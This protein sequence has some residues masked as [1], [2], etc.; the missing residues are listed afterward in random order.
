LGER[1]IGKAIQFAQTHPQS[2]D[3]KA[4]TEEIESLLVGSRADFNAWEYALKPLTGPSQE[5]SGWF[6]RGRFTIVAG[7]SGAM[8]TTFV[9]QALLSGRDGE[10]FL[11]HEPGGLSFCFLFAD[12]G[13]W[14][15][16]ETFQRMKITD[17]VP[18]QFINGLERGANLRTIAK[19]AQ[20]FTVLFIDG[21]EPELPIRSLEVCVSTGQAELADFL[22]L[23]FLTVLA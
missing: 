9:A 18:Y 11:G 10:P 8:K 1:E 7:A 4:E 5:F 15:A 13:K 3:A 12:R 6:P 2:N 20:E 16:E 21:G 17:K 23:L 22:Q 14:E 19:A